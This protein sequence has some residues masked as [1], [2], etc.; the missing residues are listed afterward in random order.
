MNFE[1]TKREI[2]FSV[3]IACAMLILGFVIAGKIN[4]AL[5]DEYQ[6][7][8]TA[9]RIGED[10]TITNNAELFEYG[11][12]TNVGNA[13]VYGDLKAVDTVTNSGIDGEYAF[14][15]KVKEVYTE[16]ERKVTYT[17]SD[18]NKQ[19]KTETYWTWDEKHRWSW[20]CNEIS[21]LG[22]VFPYETISLPSAH[23]IR[24]VRASSRVRYIYYATGTEFVGTLYAA[25]YD[26]E[27]RNALFFEDT[28]IENAIERLESGWSLRLF[29]V[30]W[31]ILTGLA[32][33]G[34][35][36]IDN[37]WLES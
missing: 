8:N 3:V 32:V 27:I 9:L 37:R 17:D 30:F 11:M 25:L 23:H 5:M 24:T 2:L 10:S 33:F 7:Y 20:H 12:R 36:Y 1:I 16:H 4:E 28:S 21:F 6:E 19:T 26:G 15:K 34:F 14:I 13:F 29:W 18:G 35:C 31:V 22:H